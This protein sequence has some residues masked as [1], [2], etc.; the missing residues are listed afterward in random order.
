MQNTVAR[1]IEKHGTTLSLADDSFSWRAFVEPL[2]YKNKLYVEESSV[3]E[4]MINRTAYRYIGPPDVILEDIAPRGTLISVM[5]T[6][7]T[8]SHSETVFF[9]SKPIYIYAVLNFYSRGK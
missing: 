2:R 4:G 1:L 5:D 7:V 3:A 8:V 9:D 6:L